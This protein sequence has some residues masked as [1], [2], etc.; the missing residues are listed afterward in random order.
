MLQVLGKG[1]FGKA[2]LVKNTEANVSRGLQ[3][4]EFCILGF[5]V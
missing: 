5:R 3:G 1:S 2:Y 4:F